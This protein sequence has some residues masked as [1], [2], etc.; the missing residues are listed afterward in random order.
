[1]KTFTIQFDYDGLTRTYID[2]SYVTKKD[3]LTYESI[4]Y[5][6]VESIIEN[7]EYKKEGEIATNIKLFDNEG[8]VLF[9]SN[10]K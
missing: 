8:N 6:I 7:E 9:N 2:K 1:M 4:A 10:N 3:D 5:N